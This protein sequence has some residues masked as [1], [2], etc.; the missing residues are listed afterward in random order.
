MAQPTP[1]V[2]LMEADAVLRALLQELLEDLAD[3]RVETTARGVTGSARA[4]SGG[5][6]LVLLDPRLPDLDGLNGCR[7]LRARVE[8]AALPSI[9]L[10]GAPTA[11]DRT[12]FLGAGAS[13]Y[14]PKPF[15]IDDLLHRV[16]AGLDGRQPGPRVS[17][18]R[19]FDGGSSILTKRPRG[20]HDH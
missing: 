15:G 2:L 1:T 16:R 8:V 4:A 18:Q 17:R 7:R 5:I 11:A 6:D 12:T 13:D 3:C 19:L 10:S 9:M 20:E 14:L